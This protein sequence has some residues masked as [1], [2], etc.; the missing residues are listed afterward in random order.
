M[1]VKWKYLNL[2]YLLLVFTIF[3]ISRTSRDVDKLK[4]FV[5]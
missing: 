4:M 3:M 5:P 2:L 1:Q